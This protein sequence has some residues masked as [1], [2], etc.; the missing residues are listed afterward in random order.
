V[1]P[2]HAAALRQG[3]RRRVFFSQHGLSALTHKIHRQLTRLVFSA[4]RLES[5]SALNQGVQQQLYEP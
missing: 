1:S 3:L 4:I 5:T 2:V